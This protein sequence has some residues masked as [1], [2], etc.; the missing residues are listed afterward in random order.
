MQ[1]TLWIQIELLDMY[2]SPGGLL[3][4]PKIVRYTKRNCKIV[5]FYGLVLADDM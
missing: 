4:R 5:I 3:I 1:I 2:Y